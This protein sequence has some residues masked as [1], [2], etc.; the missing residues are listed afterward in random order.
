M[1]MPHVWV[2]NGPLSP[3]KLFFRKTINTILMYLSAGFTVHSVVHPG[4]V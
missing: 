4:Q 2:K 1:M 3:K